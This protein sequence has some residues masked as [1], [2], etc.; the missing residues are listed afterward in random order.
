MSTTAERFRLWYEQVNRNAPE[1]IQ[2]PTPLRWSDM[3]DTTE[4][5]GWT[6][7]TPGPQQRRGSQGR[8][9]GRA[10]LTS[11]VLYA[12]LGPDNNY[13]Y[14]GKNERSNGNN[15][16]RHGGSNDTPHGTRTTRPARRLATLASIV[17]RGNAPRGSFNR[18]NRASNR[19]CGA[20]FT[21]SRAYRAPHGQ[22]DFTTSRP[23]R[24]PYSQRP[25]WPGDEN[26]NQPREQPDNNSQSS[27]HTSLEAHL[28]REPVNPS[29]S[30]VSTPPSCPTLPDLQLSASSPPNLPASTP[31]ALT[32]LRQQ[33]EA[34]RDAFV[35]NTAPHLSQN[36]RNDLAAL[37]EVSS[38]PLPHP[39]SKQNTC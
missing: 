18:G 33:A 20:D 37:V 7:G 22:R 21:T 26:Y 11:T 29:A 24:A 16:F 25:R 8:G 19:A 14:R 30:A 36:E 1:P 38:N 17:A 35:A 6:T 13:P 2:W 39:K 32:H 23:Y 31:E 12:V 3:P 34:R 15:A 28:N 5:P 10:P 9:R 27:T 4:P